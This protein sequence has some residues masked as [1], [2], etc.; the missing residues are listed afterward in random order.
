MKGG[1]FLMHLKKIEQQKS[2]IKKNETREKI[3]GV[4]IGLFLSTLC[5]T[6][7]LAAGSDATSLVSEIIKL[8]G[9]LIT[10]VGV[11]LAAVSV[12]KWV[13]S[14]INPNPSDMANTATFVA[15]AIICIVAPKVIE[16]LNLATYVTSV[17]S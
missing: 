10:I 15:G 17:I 6:P 4:A 9:N 3:T 16:G 12:Y 5:V 14:M 7:A 13:M 8:V 1:N 11:L 2:H